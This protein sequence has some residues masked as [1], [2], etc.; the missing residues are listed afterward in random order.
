MIKEAIEK[1]AQRIDLSEGEMRSCFEEM[2]SG[3]AAGADIK[4]FLEALRKKGESVT[5]ITAAAKV[6]REKSVR[7][8]VSGDI[9]LDTCGTGAVS[10]T[11]L[12]LPTILRV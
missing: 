3:K 7:I 10:Y 1:V 6:M 4:A 9:V 12:T 11:H 8:D 2:M 5:E